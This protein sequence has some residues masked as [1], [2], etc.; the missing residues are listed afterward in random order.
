LSQLSQRITAALPGEFEDRPE[1][2]SGPNLNPKGIRLRPK[3]LGDGVYA[4]MASRLPRNNTGLIVGKD[5]A[6]LIDS[7]IV[8]AMANQI[9]T[10]A[11]KLTDRPIRYLVNTTYHGDHSFG[12]ASFASDVTIIAHENAAKVMAS[13]PP[14]DKEKQ[15]RSRNMH[16][17]SPQSN[18]AVLDP[19]TTWRG[20]DVTV[21]DEMTLD[22]G[23]RR[24]RLCYFGPGN[25]RGD[26]V[27]YE[28]NT[29]TAWTGNLVGVPKAPPMLLESEPLEYTETL[30]KM[31]QTLRLTHLIPAHGIRTRGDK[32]L[33]AMIVYNID[34]HH[35]VTEALD[36]GL[37]LQQTYDGYPLNS[38]NKLPY[39]LRFVVGKLAANLHRLNLHATYV[40][41]AAARG[42][43]T[44]T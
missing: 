9:Q 44:P 16:T 43:P 39:P 42:L 23:G 8:P 14:L 35:D 21:S 3:Q 26:L 17:G 24:V 32:A 12:N 1:N 11:A 15:M 7:G 13:G 30:L 25:S 18:L 5:A 10:V 33:L 20:P 38:R 40:R 27:V 34:L 36:R 2:Y 37:T 29:Q 22:L 19:V 31:L 28:P 4:L 6:L 41:Y